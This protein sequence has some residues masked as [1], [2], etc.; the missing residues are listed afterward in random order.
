MGRIGINADETSGWAPRAGAKPSGAGSPVEDKHSRKNASVRRRAKSQPGS[1][2]VCCLWSPHN[3][4]LKIARELKWKDGKKRAAAAAAAV[5]RSV[6]VSVAA[7][8]A[9]EGRPAPIRHSLSLSSLRPSRAVYAALAGRRDDPC[10]NF[11]SLHALVVTS[12]HGP[13]S[14]TQTHSA[15]LSFTFSSSCWLTARTSWIQALLRC[16]SSRARYHFLSS[17]SLFSSLSTHFLSPSVSHNSLISLRFR[18]PNTTTYG[19]Y[20]PNNSRRGSSTGSSTPAQ[21]QRVRRS[22]KPSAPSR[23]NWLSLFSRDDAL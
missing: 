17:P 7:A 4:Q 6:I 13:H 1:V 18:S 22:R 10:L 15:S 3:N 12:L 16:S 21:Q 11:R 19:R 23:L 8:A 5:S 2:R 20:A 9:A 14:L